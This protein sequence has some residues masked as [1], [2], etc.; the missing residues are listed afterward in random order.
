MDP[1]TREVLEFDKVLELI[2]GRAASPLGRH[3]VLDLEP[4]DDAAAVMA[5]YAPLRDIISLIE[6]GDSLPLAGLFDARPLLEHAAIE[7]SAIDEEHWPRITTFLEIC[8]RLSR[9]RET[10]RETY[11][12][13]AA[14][15]DPIEPDEEL[16]RKLQHT[17]DK[18]G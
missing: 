15:L 2:A 16:L 1:R 8:L 7:G 18:E 3:F 4:L 10:H 14:L 6:R 12:H 11:P 5:R 13:L 17:L 9:F